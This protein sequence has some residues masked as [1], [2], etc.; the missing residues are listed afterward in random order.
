MVSSGNTTT[1][2]ANATAGQGRKRL[3]S[4]VN[5]AASGN[6]SIQNSRFANMKAKPLNAVGINDSLNFGG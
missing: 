2:S 3:A 1:T 6:A 5:Y 4:A